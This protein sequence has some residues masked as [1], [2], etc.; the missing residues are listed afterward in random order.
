MIAD[1]FVKVIDDFRHLLALLIVVVFA[2]SLFYSLWRIDNSTDSLAKA[3]QAVTGSLGGIVGV[4]L[5]YYFGESSARPADATVAGTIGGAPKQETSP[6]PGTEAV[7]TV[8]APRPPA[9]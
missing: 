1:L 8:A 6:A 5:G 7:P 4:I 2:I 3:L 9:G